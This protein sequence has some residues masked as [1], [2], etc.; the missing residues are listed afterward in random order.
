LSVDLSPPVLSTEGLP[1][2]LA[3]LRTQM[4]ELYDL[5]VQVR[6]DLQDA[7]GLAEDMRVLLFQSVRELLFNVVKHAGVL[8]A[9]VRVA[10][11]DTG[12]SIVVSDD[13]QGFDPDAELDSSAGFGLTSV[14][15]RIE[16]FGGDVSV[17]SAPGAGTAVHIRVPSELLQQSRDRSA[18]T[19]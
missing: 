18:N 5:D 3:W 11:E 14:R 9:T 8:R 4:H 17:S 1:E 15:K 16:L 13:G 2:A 10:D 19:A 12:L 7:P 6:T